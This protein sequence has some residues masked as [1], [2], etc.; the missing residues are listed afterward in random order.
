[1]GRLSG[2]VALITGAARG[3]GAE[4]A[5]LLAEHGAQVVVTD[6]L[7]DL[8]ADVAA[9]LGDAGRYLHLDVTSEDDWAGGVATVTAELGHID[10][11]VNNAAVL[12][13]AP[14][15]QT[16]VEDYLRIVGVNELGT[17]LGVRSVIEPMKAAGGGSIINVSSIDGI[18]AAGTTV[19][20]SASKFAV[21]GITKVAAVELGRFGIRVNCVCP[22]AGNPEMVRALLPAG[23]DPEAGGHFRF[24]V[25]RRGEMR[26]VANAILFLASDESSFFTG[27]DFI[28]DGGITAGQVVD[29]PGPP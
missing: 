7:D 24:P 5:R 26:D 14:I 6:V 2:K 11:L 3:T 23:F 8:G 28:L 20:Y 19:A 15:W 27:G 16:S 12:H 21:R 9:T 18:Y 22:A 4:T 13:L 29:V 1:M 25:G 10:V 17:F